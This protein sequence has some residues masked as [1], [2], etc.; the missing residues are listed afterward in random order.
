MRSL[1][2][3]SKQGLCPHK[4]NP[5]LGRGVTFSVAGAVLEVNPDAGQDQGNCDRTEENIRATPVNI[6][7][8]E[9]EHKH[10]PL[11]QEIDVGAGPSKERINR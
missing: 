4:Q 11:V 9:A 1:S 5:R 6:S 8:N 10:N 3:A 2:A 7:G